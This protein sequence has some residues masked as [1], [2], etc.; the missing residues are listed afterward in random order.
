MLMSDCLHNNKFLF[1]FF[2]K[3]SNVSVM[4]V[5][6]LSDIVPYGL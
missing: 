2:S 6:V 4:N 3:P 5:T 1:T